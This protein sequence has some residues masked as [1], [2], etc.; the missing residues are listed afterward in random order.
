[1]VTVFCCC[2]FLAIRYSAVFGYCYSA[3]LRHLSVC[4]AR[5][6]IAEARITLLLLKM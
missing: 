3:S 2:Y 4:D 5:D 6:K 1:M